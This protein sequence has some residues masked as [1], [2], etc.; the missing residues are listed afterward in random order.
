MLSSVAAITALAT[1]KPAIAQTVETIYSI[2]PGPLNQALAAFGRQSGI[3]ITYV[4]SNAASK[5]SPGVSGR[6]SPDAAIA[7]ILTDSGLSYRFTNPRTIVISPIGAGSSQAGDEATALAPIV[8]S[9]QSAYGPVDGYVATSASSAMKGDISILETPQAISV[10]TADRIEDQAAQS[11]NEALRYTAGVRSETSGA[12]MMDNPLYLRGF[13]QSSLEMYQDGLRAVTPGY[14]GFFAADPYGLERVEVL[15]GPSSVLYGQQ[16]PGGLINVVSKRPTENPINEVETTIGSFSHYQGAFDIGGTNEDKSIM[17]RMVGMAREAETQVDYVDNDRRY[18]APSITWTP[19]EDTKLT[20]L[21]SYQR[22]DGDF[23][24]QVPAAAVLLPNPNGHI[25]FSRFVG[26]PDWEYE[27]SR[28]TAIGYEFEHR[29]NDTVQFE[30]N[31]RYTHLTNHRQYLQ[32]SGALVDNRLLNR[33]YNLR[34]ID[35]DGIAVDSRFRFDFDTGP[36]EHRA[37]VGLDYLWGK[38]RWLE[39]RGTATAIDIYNP[40]YG[41][42]VDTSV[43]TTK[44]LSDINASQAGLYLQDQLKID[45]LILTLGMRQDWAWRDTD[46]LIT[47]TTT[48]QNDHAFTKKAGLTYLFD[49]GIAPYASYAE[50]FNPIVGTDSLGQVFVPETAQQW[51]VGVK[52]QPEGFDGLFTLSAFDLRRQNVQTYDP[53]DPRYTL[54]T[55]EIRARGIEFEAVAN[56]SDGVSLAAAYTYTDAEITETKTTNQLG[57][58]PYRVPRHTASLWLNYELQQEALDGLSVGAGV[59]Y[60]GETWGN[61]DNTFKVPS[62]TLVDLAV[63]YDFGKKFPEAKGLAASLNVSNLFDKYYVPGCFTVNGCNYGSQRTVIGK[64]SYQW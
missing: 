51:E 37:I 48:E 2:A 31:F 33:T 21:G 54:Q 1:E 41:S 4:P 38:S 5:Q 55:G 3:Q 39:Q 27:T 10:V 50:S 60:I 26:E 53:S 62:F 36:I 24:A 11:I 15:K 64:L 9:G 19:D 23:Y 63:R 28:R 44:S 6:L 22:N 30:Q 49:N 13:Q 32:A 58:T 25:P 29:F 35:N 7:R 20:V 47:D 45:N 14:F 43:D 34:D 12:Q 61:D 46:N 16:A 59:R 18:L 57:N 40:V 56:L 17:Y 42:P 52:Y 8:I